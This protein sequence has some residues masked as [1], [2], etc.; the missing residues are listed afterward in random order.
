VAPVAFE[1]VPS[2]RLPPKVSVSVPPIVR[3]AFVKFDAPVT[4]KL[5]PEVL[6]FAPEVLTVS[7][8]PTEVFPFSV[9]V[10]LD[11][12]RELRPVLFKVTAPEVVIG[13]ELPESVVIASPLPL[14]PARVAPELPTLKVVM[15]AAAAVPV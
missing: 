14:P 4:L 2:V 12:V 9:S 3:V 1:S 5:L 15:V 7:G 13:T 6:K 11:T 10:P 8:P